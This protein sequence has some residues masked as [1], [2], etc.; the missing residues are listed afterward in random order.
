MTEVMVATWAGELERELY[1]CLDALAFP[2]FAKGELP[3]SSRSFGGKG[4][5]ACHK[6][7]TKRKQKCKENQISKSKSISSLKKVVNKYSPK[8]RVAYSPPKN[9]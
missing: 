2:W 9:V 4:L 6:S 1:W 3:A 8:N 7:V 5:K